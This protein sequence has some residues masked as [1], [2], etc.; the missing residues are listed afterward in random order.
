[1]QIFRDKEKDKYLMTILC[2]SNVNYKIIYICA[3]FLSRNGNYLVFRHEQ[4]A[5]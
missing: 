4:N 5:K 1:M 3:H 2:A